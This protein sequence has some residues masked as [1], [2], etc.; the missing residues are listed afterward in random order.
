M[1]CFRSRRLRTAK[2][3]MRKP[4][5]ASGSPCLHMIQRFHGLIS[6]TKGKNY[7]SM[8]LRYRIFLWTVL[9]CLLA[10]AGKGEQLK[11]SLMDKGVILERIKQSLPKNEQREE[12]IKELFTNA[13]CAPAMTDQRVKAAGNPNII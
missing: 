2:N 7:S 12:K 3:T 5:P 9:F 11:F 4:Y 13:G 1:T 8:Q 6:A 10:G